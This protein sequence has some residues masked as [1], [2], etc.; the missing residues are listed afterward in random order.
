MIRPPVITTSRGLRKLYRYVWGKENLC[1]ESIQKNVW[2]VVLM[3]NMFLSIQTGIG[4]FELGRKEK[5][6]GNR[7]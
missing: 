2:R 7:D 4:S 3:H 5:W 6:E 1:S